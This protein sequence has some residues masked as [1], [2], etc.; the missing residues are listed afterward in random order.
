MNRTV[1]LHSRWTWMLLDAGLIGLA[2]S[3]SWYVR[4]QLRWFRGVEPSYYRDLSAY[5]PL[6]AGLTVVLLLA[7]NAHGV[8]QSRRGT[9]WIDEMFRIGSGTMIGIV[10]AMAVTFGLRPLAFS[11]LLF[12]YDS[13]LIL[14]LL[15]MARGVRHGLETYLRKRGLNVKNILI[16]GAGEMGRAVMRTIVA[17]PQLGYHVV[18]FLDNDPEDG[19][20]DIGRFKALGGLERLEI[21]VKQEQVQEV[22][23]TL[24][25]H[26]QPIIVE[27]MHT[28]E[29]LRVRSRVVPDMFQLSLSRVS[30]DDLS[31]IP[32]IGLKATRF[33]ETGRLTKR[34]LDLTLAVL[35]MLLFAPVFLVIAILIRLDSPGPVLFRQERVGL[36]GG[37]F[38][39]VKFRSM[40]EGAERQRGALTDL[41]QA[42]VPLFK[43]RDDPRLT[44]VGPWLRR[45]S[46][47]ELP[48]LLNVIRGEMSL[49]GPRP[50]LPEEV[51]QYKPWH[52][53]RLDVL[54]GITGLWQVSGRSN[55]TFDEMCLLDIYYIENW[56]LAMDLTLISRTI[57]RVFI[58]RGA[59]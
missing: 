46:L 33:T 44:R 36:K 14:I 51:Q 13:V 28:C 34:V 2:C 8:Y 55:I 32:L 42:S 6:F 26:S 23:I 5:G 12:L 27:L 41:N 38:R 17:R 59:Y 43:I 19:R 22:I 37:S 50:G 21:V 58:G 52:R 10:L 48:Q 29:K 15:G 4:Y 30:V 35:G 11:R 25:W 39:I 53:Q 18:G 56:S 40:K 57:P 20:T 47:D 49:V 7:F 16:I 31:G 24:P 9:S 54:P 3:L 45:V 1:S